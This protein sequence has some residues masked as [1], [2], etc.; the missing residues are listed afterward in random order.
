MQADVRANTGQWGMRLSR[1]EKSGRYWDV[2]ESALRKLSQD[3]LCGNTST[4]VPGTCLLVLVSKNIKSIQES[5]S[6]TW[7]LSVCL[8]S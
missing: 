8:S 4:C 1:R 6:Q 7:C 3:M 5:G 2:K